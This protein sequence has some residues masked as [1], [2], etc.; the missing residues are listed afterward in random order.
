MSTTL[1]VP[2]AL[3][4]AAFVIGLVAFL[5]GGAKPFVSPST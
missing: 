5:R 2:L 3:S 1:R 4:L